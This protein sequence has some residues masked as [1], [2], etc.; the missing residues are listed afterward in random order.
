MKH[1]ISQLDQNN[2]PGTVY[3]F[4][5]NQI[6]WQKEVHH[7]AIFFDDC[8]NEQEYPQWQRWIFS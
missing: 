6:V 8:D 1:F 4:Y 5:C 3:Q 7:Q 2:I